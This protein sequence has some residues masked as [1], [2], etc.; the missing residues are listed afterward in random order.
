[1][2][3]SCRDTKVLV[4]TSDWCV[5]DRDVWNQV[6]MKSILNARL[7]SF[8]PLSPE[9]DALKTATAITLHETTQQSP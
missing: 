1:M 3:A 8:L 7:K 5:F 4:L 6:D 9:A 2:C